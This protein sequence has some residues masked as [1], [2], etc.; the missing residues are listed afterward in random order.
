MMNLDDDLKNT[1]MVIISLKKRLQCGFLF[2][3][4]S[5]SADRTASISF[6][7]PAPD[8]L[9]YLDKVPLMVKRQGEKRNMFDFFFSSTIKA[10]GSESFPPKGPENKYWD[11]RIRHQD[12]ERV[13]QI[14]A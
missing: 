3:F 8:H 10:R 12:R 11:L 9:I 6:T 1:G 7:V 14:L 5:N 2:P 13:E 4:N